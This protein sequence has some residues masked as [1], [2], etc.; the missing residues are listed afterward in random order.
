MPTLDFAVLTGYTLVK[1]SSGIH[2]ILTYFHAGNQFYLTYLN[3]FQ[4]IGCKTFCREK[5]ILWVPL[6]L[7]ID[8]T[9]VFLLSTSSDASNTIEG[10]HIRGWGQE[11]ELCICGAGLAKHSA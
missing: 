8:K 9:A 1:A 6:G 10:R 5:P 3:Q 2:M 4:L 11:G 7:P